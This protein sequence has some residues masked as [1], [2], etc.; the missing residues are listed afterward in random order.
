MKNIRGRIEF[1]RNVVSLTKSPGGFVELVAVT[2]TFPYQ[3]VLEALKCGIKHIG[4]SKVQEALPKFKQLGFSLGGIA[5][6]FI[7]HLQSN[8]VRRVVENFDLIHS[9]DTLRLAY[10]ISRH[11]RG[12]N[13]LQNCLIEVKVS[14]EISKI[15]IAPDD[16]EEFYRKCL[17]IPSIVIRGLMVITPYSK[18]SGDSRCYFKQVYGLF[19]NIKKSFKSSEFDVLSMG[20]SND[21]KVAIEEGSNMIRV[22]SAIFEERKIENE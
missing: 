9:L 6:H 8:K 3:S 13:K 16:V 12:L 19:K 4:E 11:A 5:K 17:S 21:Y 18:N 1:L 10:D 22:G 14:H 2:K 15:G 20:M 7:G